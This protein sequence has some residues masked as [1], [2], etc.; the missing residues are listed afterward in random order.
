MKPHQF[1]NSGDLEFD[2][3]CSVCGGKHRDSIHRHPDDKDIG[4]L[5][6]DWPKPGADYVMI[7]GHTTLVRKG[8]KYY[9]PNGEW[10]IGWVWIDGSQVTCCP[11]H[12]HID[13]VLMLPID[14]ERFEEG[15]GYSYEPS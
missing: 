4:E 6:R 8:D 11:E 5:P 1:V 2:A 13:G 3:N 14:K 9:R 10:E 7:C 15:N 12:A